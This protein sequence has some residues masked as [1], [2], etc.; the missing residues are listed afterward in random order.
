M[1]TFLHPDI[2]PK[3]YAA[4]AAAKLTYS[5][6]LEVQTS[7][8]HNAEQLLNTHF[9]IKFSPVNPHLVK[10]QTSCNVI[11]QKPAANLGEAGKISELVFYSQQ[12]P[13]PINPYLT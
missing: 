7:F 1:N 8:C 11:L 6:I 5:K 9:R 10:S 3:D 4:H 13:P 12:R 2:S